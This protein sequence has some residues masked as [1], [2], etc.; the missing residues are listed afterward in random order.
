MSTPKAKSVDVALD[1]TK[2]LITLAAGLIPTSIALVNYIPNIPRGCLTLLSISC[3]A[4]LLSMVSGILV[5]G[6]VVDE[7]R[8][9][10]DYDIVRKGNVRN[11]ALVQWIL[12]ILGVLMMMVSLFET[13]RNF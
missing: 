10:S 9:S 13:F 8:K 1:V 7:L 4:Y 2:L 3:L 11:P 5:F 12:F 6:E